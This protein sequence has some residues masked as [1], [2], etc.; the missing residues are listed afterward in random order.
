M[1]VTIE[2]RPIGVVLG[3]CVTASINSDYSSAFATVNKTS[4]NLQ[5]GDYVYIQSNVENYNG[6]WQIEVTNAN[7]FLLIDNPYVAWI[8]DADITYCPGIQTHGWSCVHLPIV[9][10]VSN[11]K[12]PTNSVDTSRT[13]SSI[14]DDNGLVNANLSGSLGTFEDL[15]FVK[16]SNCPDPA[17]DGIYQILDK[18]ATNDVTLNLDYASTPASAITGATIQLYYSNYNIVVKVYA[19][20]NSSHQWADQKP[21]ELA[22]TLELIPDENNRSKFSINEILKSYIQTTNNLL[23]ATL[24]NN[25]DVWTQFYIEVGEQYDT[26]NGYTVTTFEGAFA[27]DQSAF[28]GYGVNAMLEFKN[29]HSGYLSAYLNPITWLTLFSELTIFSDQYFDISFIQSFTNI[30]VAYRVKNYIN[31]V[32]Q[33]TTDYQF[34]QT[35]ITGVFR[36]KPE[37]NVTSDQIKVSIIPVSIVEQPENNTF[38]GT[39]APWQS[40]NLDGTTRIAWGYNSNQARVILTPAANSEFLYIEYP[41]FNG[42]IYQFT[43]TTTETGAGAASFN[44]YGWNPGESP[45]ALATGITAIPSTVFSPTATK[46]FKYIVF[47]AFEITGTD[48]VTL[49]IDSVVVSFTSGSDISDEL[50]INISNECTQQSTDIQWINNLGGFDAWRFTGETG[51]TIDITGAGE[52]KQNIFPE[53]PKSYGEH[54]D[55]IRKQTFRESANRKF[56]FSQFLTQDQADALAYL[57]S[58]PLVQIVNSRQDRRT[59]IVD[60]DSFSKYEDGDKT[61]TISFN[62]LYTDDI[63]SQNI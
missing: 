4:H 43:V 47:E 60:T 61:Y 46:F 27:S 52:T 13:I 9:Y 28:E 26:S 14:T 5:D 21:Y 23:L 36:F 49:D 37:F 19:G 2:K 17:Y 53:W 15:S 31:D 29:V 3:T 38:T 22:A 39:I 11:T 18:L 33:S 1:A 16:I 62:I 42:A 25:I 24:P 12:Y 34:N 56:I 10:E 30:S 63:P 45:V 40:I 58:S 48:P 41:F 6:F 50:T 7:E 32:L 35:A 20:I 44:F 57:K 8:V 55:T 54:A 59:V 51:H